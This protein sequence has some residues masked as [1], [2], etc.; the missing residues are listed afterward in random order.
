MSCLITE[1]T[2]ATDAAG[3]VDGDNCVTADAADVIERVDALLRDPEALERITRA[4][5]DLVHARHTIRQRDEIMQWSTL[6]R[7]LA[8]S[9]RIVP[10]VAKNGLPEARGRARGS[11]PLRPRDRDRAGGLAEARGGGTDGGLVSRPAATRS[12]TL[13]PQPERS[14]AQW[15]GDVA[16]VLEACG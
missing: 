6:H 12:F 5:H 10:G 1:R 13:H 2:A 11:P 3:F 15:L 4:G 7:P 8:P 9:Q 14:D 16:A